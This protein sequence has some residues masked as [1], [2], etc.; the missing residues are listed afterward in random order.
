M[1]NVIKKVSA[2]A[3]AF[4]LLGTG[5]VVSETVAHKSNNTLIAQAGATTTYRYSQYWSDFFG[6]PAYYEYYYGSPTGRLYLSNSK[7][8]VYLW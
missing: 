3:M 4:T 6:Q 7:S 8:Y 5:T 1:K 2:I